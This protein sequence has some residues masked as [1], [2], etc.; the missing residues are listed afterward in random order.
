[1]EGIV[2]DVKAKK[3]CWCSKIFHFEVRI[4]FVVNFVSSVGREAE[5]KD[6][7]DIETRMLRFSTYKFEAVF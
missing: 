3:G 1:M 2:I 5:N 7:V 4:K 6:I